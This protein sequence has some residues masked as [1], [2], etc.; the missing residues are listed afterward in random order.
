ML[1]IYMAQSPCFF[2]SLCWFPLAPFF[3]PLYLLGTLLAVIGS[4]PPWSPVIR[5]LTSPFSTPPHSKFP[6]PRLIVRLTM[7]TS[8]PRLLLSGTIG[9]LSKA[10]KRMKYEPNLVKLGRNADLGRRRTLEDGWWGGGVEAAGGSWKLGGTEACGGLR[11]RYARLH[12]AWPRICPLCR[13][14]NWNILHCAEAFVETYGWYM[15]YRGN[16]RNMW[17]VDYV[18]TTEVTASSY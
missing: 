13:N 14:Y 7:T 11:P 8:R 9:T 5:K 12:H 3:I 6:A 1:T 17:K 10:E 15:Y 4:R 16:Y 18:N 2:T